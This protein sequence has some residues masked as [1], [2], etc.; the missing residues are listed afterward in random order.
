MKVRLLG[1]GTSSGVPRIGADGPDWGNCDPSNP[2]NRRTRA[3][4]IVE[5]ATTRLLIDTS[6]DMR[7]Q[8]LAAGAPRIDAV[9]WTHEHA[10]HV[11]GIDDLRQLFQLRGSPVPCF[12]RPDALKRLLNRFH[13]AFQGGGPYPALLT[14]TPITG[15][16]TIGDIRIEHVDM[17]HGGITSAGFRFSSGGKSVSYATDFAQITGAMTALFRGSDIFVVDALRRRPHPTHPHLDL[18]LD[19]IATTKPGRAVLMHMDSSMDYAK[20]SAELPDGVEPGYDTME[21]EA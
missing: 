6:P 18:T 5:S 11:H 3:S 10:D 7:E 15:P 20:L 17:P 16:F 9:L 8:L 12:A 21:L 4:I 14:G 13:Y 19:F 2:R 1:S